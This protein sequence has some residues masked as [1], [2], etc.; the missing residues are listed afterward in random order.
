M[1]C[2]HVLLRW[3]HFTS[4]E[5]VLPTSCVHVR[6]VGLWAKYGRCFVFH[7]SE[8][9]NN[10]VFWQLFLVFQWQGRAKGIGS[11]CI[12]YFTDMPVTIS[13]MFTLVHHDV[14]VVALTWGGVHVTFWKAVTRGATQDQ[15]KQKQHQ[16]R[17][18]CTAANSQMK[19]RLALKNRREK[20]RSRKCN[21]KHEERLST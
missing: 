14:R 9:F 5:V 11:P 18:K 3:F 4:M 16:P 13:P 1:C 17:L 21:V 19:H 7:H 10:T 8:R 20:D 12:L 6:Q 2:I 15:G